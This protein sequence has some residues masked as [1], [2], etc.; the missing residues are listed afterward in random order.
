MVGFS[1][2]LTFED[3]DDGITL[4]HL[5]PLKSGLV[6]MR[7]AMTVQNSLWNEHKI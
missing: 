4:L 7:S 6:V 1:G 5:Y 2:T 3:G